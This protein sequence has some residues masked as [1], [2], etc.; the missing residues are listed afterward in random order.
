MKPEDADWLVYHLIPTSGCT[1]V[2]DLTAK[3][4]LGLPVLEES[5]GRLERYCLIERDEASIRMLTFGESLIRNQ[6]IYEKDLP[7]VIEK[8]VIKTRKT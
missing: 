5:L 2:E 6:M 3:S 8:G 7:F 4:G 1:T